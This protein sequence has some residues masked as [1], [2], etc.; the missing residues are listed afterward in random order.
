MSQIAVRCHPFAPVAAEELQRWL[1]AEID[2]LRDI[3]P[4]AAIRL[5]RLSQPGPEAEIEVG[6]QIEIGVAPPVPPIDD[7]SLNELLSDLRL[8][9]VQPSVLQGEGSGSA[10]LEPAE[11]EGALA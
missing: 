1:T 5:L 10:S 8:L 9:G 2:R 7:R 11:C 6:W 4:E 3:A